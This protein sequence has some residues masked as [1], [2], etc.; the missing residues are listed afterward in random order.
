MKMLCAT[1]ALVALLSTTGLADQ[2][3]DERTD[4]P[5]FST[6]IRLKGGEQ[7][8]ATESPGHACPCWYDF[9]GDGAKDLIVGQF[10]GGKMKVYRNL[11]DGQ[12]AEGQ[13]LMVGDTP[14]EVPGIW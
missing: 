3:D 13:W 2:P 11:G 1:I 5:V 9:D 4:G 10:R 7:F 6:P 8:I 12:L 14:A